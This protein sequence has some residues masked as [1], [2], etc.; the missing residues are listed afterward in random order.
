ML[1]FVFTIYS[2]VLMYSTA[3]VTTALHDFLNH[4]IRLKASD[5]VLGICNN[6]SITVDGRPVRCTTSFLPD[7]LGVYV[8]I[9]SGKPYVRGK[10]ANAF[11]YLFNQH[12]FRCLYTDG[13]T[14]NMRIIREPSKKEQEHIHLKDDWCQEQSISETTCTCSEDNFPE[15]SLKVETKKLPIS[16]LLYTLVSDD[17]KKINS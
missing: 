4:A 3:I 5:I 17:V 11:T 16:H 8:E 9:L 12:S 1:D 14:L 13:A 15:P 6:T 2:K 7:Q 10:S